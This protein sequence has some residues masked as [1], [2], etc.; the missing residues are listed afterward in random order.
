MTTSQPTPQ[1]STEARGPLANA[2]ISLAQTPDDLPGIDA[3]LA[4]IARMTADRVVGVDYA[5]I[6]ALR[7][8]DSITVAASSEIAESVDQAQYDDGDGPCM[9]SLSID[10]PVTVADITGTM[11]WPGFHEAAAA[12]GLHASTSIPLAAG[13]GT[14][15]AV[16]NLYGHDSIAMA[17]LIAGVW[18]VYDPAQPMPAGDGALPALDPGAA[19]LLAGFA[20]AL[21]VRAAIQLALRIIMEGT[22]CTARDAY[23]TLRL[24]AADTGASLLT[25]AETVIERGL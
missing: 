5:S 20:E 8:G 6:T 13:S 4:A 7:G 1:I 25:A 15:V 2:L 12:L 17:P 19:E 9:R 11:T 14:P 10:S 21:S 24:R 18:A 23:V 3:Q 22:R 16:L